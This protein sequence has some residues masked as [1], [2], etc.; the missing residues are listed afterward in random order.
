MV[1]GNSKG[2]VMKIAVINHDLGFFTQQ[3][4]TVQHFEDGELAYCDHAGAVTE[5]VEIESINIEGPDDV[6]VPEM[7]VCDKENCGAYRYV[8]ERTWELP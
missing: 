2:T 1:L 5:P 6:Q 7:E 4:I 3:S 8:G